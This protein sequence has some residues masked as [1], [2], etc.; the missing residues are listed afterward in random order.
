MVYVSEKA[1]TDEASRLG[2]PVTASPCPWGET[3]KRQEM[4]ELLRSLEPRFP[5]LKSQI[6]HALINVKRSDVWGFDD[7]SP[8][9]P[10]NAP[11]A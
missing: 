8:E 10:I 5:A 6:L 3:T 4:K 2:L 7:D 11:S 9:S 1:I